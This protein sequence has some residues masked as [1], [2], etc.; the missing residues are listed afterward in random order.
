MDDDPQDEPA[1]EAPRDA[2]P[3]MPPDPFGAAHLS[4]VQL[5]AVY[6]GLCA[7]GFRWSEALF[8]LAAANA[9]GAVLA[10]QEL[11]D[12]QDGQ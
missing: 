9:L 3:S 7:A 12:P 6:E 2:G 1:G 10:A 11:Q 5:R 4:F 8:F